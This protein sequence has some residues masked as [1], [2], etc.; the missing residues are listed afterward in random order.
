MFAS[1]YEKRSEVLRAPLPSLVE[2]VRNEM[3]ENPCLDYDVDAAIESSDD[4][5]C[6]ADLII[7]KHP[8]A[9][10]AVSIGKDDLP[11]LLVSRRYEGMLDDPLTHVEARKFIEK[12]CAA[13]RLLIDAIDERAELLLGL[14]QEIIQRQ[15]DFLQNGLEFRVPWSLKEIA[16]SLGI[17][18]R[19]AVELVEGKRL[20]A[21][22]GVFDLRELF[23]D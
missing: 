16:T 23:D 14:G 21:P 6:G 8:D 2:L 12:K 15:G 1:S 18:P 7:R 19:I 10:Y 9:D 5:S 22:S 11:R 3:A 20:A 4:D 17:S 13:A